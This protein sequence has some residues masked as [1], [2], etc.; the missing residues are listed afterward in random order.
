LS[1]NNIVD[2]ELSDDGL[3]YKWVI[4]FQCIQG[5]L[6]G[7]KFIKFFALNFYH[8]SFLDNLQNIEEMDARARDAGLA[9]FLDYHKGAHV[10]D[11]TGCVE[12]H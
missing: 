2:I 8:K 11:H 6:W 4:E 12:D 1:S 3:S 10:V 9:P 7:L 5:N